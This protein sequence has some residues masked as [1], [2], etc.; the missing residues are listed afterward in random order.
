MSHSHP[1]RTDEAYHKIHNRYLYS[2]RLIHIRSRTKYANDLRIQSIITGYRK[3]VTDLAVHTYLLETESS[4]AT[5]L[6][7]EYPKSQRRIRR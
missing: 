3:H 7:N 6:G 5:F 4:S 2:Y 1:S